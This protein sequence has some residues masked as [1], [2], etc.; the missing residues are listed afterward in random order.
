MGKAVSGAELP[1]RFEAMLHHNLRA[2][3]AETK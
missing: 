2:D 3:A 1:L